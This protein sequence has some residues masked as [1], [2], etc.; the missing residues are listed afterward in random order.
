M[1]GV[2]IPLLDF[3]LHSCYNNSAIL[4]EKTLHLFHGK[5]TFQISSSFFN[6]KVGKWEPIVEK[7]EFNLDLEL[8]EITKFKK[9]IDITNSNQDILNINIS[10]EMVFLPYISFF[11][12]VSLVESD[13]IGLERLE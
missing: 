7:W 3:S 11:D 1:S 10:D 2:A 5:N 4:L 13:L 6:S 8:G 12:Y 9:R